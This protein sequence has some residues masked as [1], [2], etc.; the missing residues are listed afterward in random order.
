MDNEIKKFVLDFLKDRGP[1]I[2]QLQFLPLQG[3]GSKRLFR[4]VT[5]SSSRPGLIAMAN[6]PTDPAAMR[7]NLAYLNIGNHL[8][9]KGIPVPKIYKSDLESGLFLME[10][11]GPAS[12]QD[13]VLSNQDPVPVYE[14]VLEHLVGLQTKGA[15]GFDTKWCCETERYDQTVM[16]RYEADYFRDAFLCNYLGLKGEW[17]QLDGPFDYLA[18]TA[19][20]AD[21]R[22][23]LHRDFQS[24]NIMIFKEN[25]GFID[26]QGARLGPL[27]Y[28]LASLLID[29]Y[30]ELLPE[31]R[32]GF[33]EHYLLL[34]RE[35]DAGLIDDFRTY[36]P[37]LAIQRNLQ[38]LGA[39]SFLTKTMN[40]TYFETYIPSAL[41]TLH[42]LLYQLN[43]SRLSPLSDVVK[44]LSTLKNLST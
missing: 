33:Y 5:F 27:G 15:E 19:S 23:L 7:E 6:P 36:Y 29:P 18:E 11:L 30:T 12:L 25:T 13:I 26:W 8:Y 39:F 42:D 44:G 20:G 35:Y 31:Q 21:N 9:H 10:D 37:Y 16:R 28:D 41:K 4:R 14:K 22:F 2:D 1:T 3:D 32:D 34:I 24:R 40:K 38:I 17:P 43:D